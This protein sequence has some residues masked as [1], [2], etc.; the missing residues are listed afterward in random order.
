M[1]K[2]KST[3]KVISLGEFQSQGG[4]MKSNRNAL[5]SAPGEQ[6]GMGGGYGGR[7][8]RRGGSSGGYNQERSRADES[9]QWRSGGGK[10]RDRQSSSN[11][12]RPRRS[13]GGD[14]GGGRREGGGFGGRRDRGDRDGGDREERVFN[15]DSFG[16]KKQGAF[17]SDDSPMRRNNNR[18]GGGD[19]SY[20]GDRNRNSPRD[21]GPSLDRSTFGKR[22]V[23]VRIRN[24]D[25]YGGGSRGGGMGRRNRDI[26]RTRR[27]DYDGSGTGFGAALVADCFAPIESESTADRKI[28]YVE[29]RR[30]PQRNAWGATMPQKTEEEL[31][32]ERVAA[33]EKKEKMDA[34][35]ARKQ[36]IRDERKRKK[37]AKEAEEK[38]KADEIRAIEDEKHRVE[39]L[40][41]DILDMVR[42]D[43]DPIKL[44]EEQVDVTLPHLDL[45]PEEWEKLGISL[46]MT[47]NDGIV[48][49]R[50]AIEQLPDKGFDVITICMCSTYSK[51]IGESKFLQELE[52]Q[53]INLEDLVMDKDGYQDNLE[54]YKLTCLIKNEESTGLFEECFER[55]VD[56][57]ELQEIIIQGGKQLSPSLRRRVFTYIW[58]EYFTKRDTS[59]PGEYFNNQQLFLDI[60]PEEENVHE[61][62]DTCMESW[63]SAGQTAG[64]LVQTFDHL[65]RTFVVP[66]ECLI[67]WNSY[68]QTPS[69]ITAMLSVDEYRYKNLGE[70]FEGEKFMDYLNQVDEIYAEEEEEEQGFGFDEYAE[71]GL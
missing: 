70:V 4:G 24:T 21:D 46:G 44:T 27:G 35:R 8:G 51:R 47:V 29:E 54:K 5:P 58:D 36:A 67:D 53:G 12:D 20:G 50:Q 17:R 71:T 43:G 23:S 38:R 34:E 7:G 10:P 11:Y 62:L 31:E 65:I 16:S 32:A 26:D 57:T 3:K 40:K 63:N 14:S 15:R 18:Y 59:N 42:G 64:I 55:H 33:A 66:H 19:R 49:L 6:G 13:F 37:D 45:A 9:N 48:T 2:K 39:T 56:L 22:Q 30:Q 1:V 69:K 60:T 52:T 68:S 61:L 25:S 41:T 28:N